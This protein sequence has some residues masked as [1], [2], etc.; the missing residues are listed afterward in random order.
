MKLI[1][2]YFMKKVVLLVSI[3][4][5]ILLGCGTENNQDK[6]VDNARN[7]SEQQKLMVSA[8]ASLTDAMDEITEK[9]EAEHP[10]IDL[11]FNFAGSGKLAQQIQQGAPVDVFISANE[12]W[13]DTLVHGEEIDKSERLDVTG[14]RLVMITQNDTDIHYESFDEIDGSEL[15]QIAIGNL[16]SVPAGEYSKEVLDRLEKWDELENQ[17]VYAKDVRQVLTYVE[18][19]NAD[20]GFVYE[21]DALSSDN[22]K[23]ITYADPE[24]HDEIIYPGAIL[25]GSEVQKE[26]KKFL[27]YLISEEGQEILEKHGFS[28]ED[29]A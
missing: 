26:G 6:E 25:S 15:D 28:K 1:G 12:S 29:K 21:S 19:G 8:A 24:A 11:E 2:D 22:V 7:D 14:N 23:I 20:I 16:D 27:E 10:G 3:I 17:F 13:M 9:Y 4:S 18:S 5:V